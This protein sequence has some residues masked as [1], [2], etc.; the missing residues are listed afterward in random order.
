MI[1]KKLSKAL[2]PV[3]GLMGFILATGVVEL[4]VFAADT[5]TTTTTTTT[6]QASVT[7]TDN[8]ASVQPKDY[9]INTNKSVTE[10]G[11]KV[12]VDKAIATKHKLKVTLKIEGDKALEDFNHNNSIF[13]VT[14]GDN[15]SS[16]GSSSHAQ[17][18]DDKT[19][20]L[21]LEKENYRGEYPEKGAMRVD[22]ALSNYK[23]NIGMD[24]PVDFSS[25]FENYYTK[26]IS[27][28][29]PQFDYALNSLESDVM[30][31]TISYTKP[32]HD[33]YD[34]ID[35]N[36]TLWNSKILL[37]VGD[38]MY[39]TDSNGNYS[40]DDK[41]IMGNYVS[42]LP[43]YDIIKNEK[44]ISIVP[45]FSNISIN[46]LDDLNIHDDISKQ[47][48]TK[49]ILNNIS[50]EKNFSFSDGS[51]GELYNIE[52]NDNSIKVACKGQSEI[53]SLLM[54]SNLNLN[55]EYVKGQKNNTFYNN[56]AI[57]IYKDPKDSL[58]YIVEFYN[59]QKDKS[60][61]L[62]LDPMIK[63]VNMYKLGDEIKLLN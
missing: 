44:N 8:T 43:T 2:G 19:M 6:T 27:A 1:N 57:C 23:V 39:Q 7:Y 14:Y 60:T 55:Y 54:A 37:K 4:P 10:N 30:G 28:K 17:L 51:K 3:L 13:A 59:V 49:D 56:Q 40:G 48:T 26:N 34:D 61:N 24:I 58:G 36:D 18:L 50:Y 45:I 21:T 63:Q 62:Y 53:E 20:L 9:S 12:T 35:N 25:S 33:E 11:I 29:I 52:R 15:D 5:T 32:K 31:T 38:K 42:T 41:K 47:N 46:D 22:V 16:F